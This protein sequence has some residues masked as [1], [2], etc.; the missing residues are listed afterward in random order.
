MELLTKYGA[1]NNKHALR[2]VP[3]T[4]SSYGAG[5]SRYKDN[6][7]FLD[8]SIFSKDSEKIL[9]TFDVVSGEEIILG[10]ET[11]RSRHSAEMQVTL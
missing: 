5:L 10:I 7:K 2:Y 8:T 9:K 11:E 4:R 6:L 3:P 1:I